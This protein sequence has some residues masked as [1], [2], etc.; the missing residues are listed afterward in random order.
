MY[1]TTPLVAVAGAATKVGVEFDRTMSKVSAITGATGEDFDSLRAKAM[2]L[3]NT[4]KYSSTEI[5][6]AMTF[7]GMAGYDTKQILDSLNGVVSLSIAGGVSL[8]KASD[9]VTDSLTGMQ[10]SAKDCGDFVDIMASTIT[11]SNTSVEL[12][13]ET[14]KYVAPV[15]GALGITM[16]DLS[17]AIG[18]AGN[19]GVKGSQAGTAL[20]GGLTRLVEPTTKAKAAMDKYGIALQK[21]EDGTV[22]L[23]DTLV[24]LR[25]K[26]GK[27]DATTQASAAATIFGKEAMSSWM[28]IINASDDDFQNLRTNINGSTKVMTFFKEGL[29]Q[30]GKEGKEL[31]KSLNKLNEVYEDNKMLADAMNISSTDLGTA[32]ALLGND[33]KVASKNVEGLLSAVFDMQNPTKETKKAMDDLGIEVARLGD[34]SL[35]LNGTLGN[36]RQAMSN[37]SEEEKKAVIESLNLKGGQEDLLEILSLTDDEFQNTTE[38]M[39]DTKGASEKLAEIMGENLGKEIDEMKSSLQTSLIKVFETL[40]PLLASVIEKITDMAN[41]FNELSDAEREQVVKIAGLVACIGPLLVVLGNI[42]SFGGSVAMIFGGMSLAGVSL[43]GILGALSAV[44]IPALIAILVGLATVI[45]DNENAIY[46][47]QEKFGSLGTIVSGVCEFISGA[48]QLTFG[49]LVN[50]LMLVFDLIAAALDGPGGATMEEAFDT[51]GTRIANTTEEAMQK[52]ALSST[53]AMSQLRNATDEQLNGTVQSMDTILGQLPSIIDGNYSEATNALSNQLQN[54]DASQLTILKGMN[55]ST[56]MIFK[57]I[58]EN[59]TVDQMKERLELNFKQMKNTGQMDAE[60]LEKNV[61][62]AMELMKINMDVKTEEGAKEVT[63]NIAKASQEVKNKTDKIN[64]DTTENLDKASKGAKKGSDK[65]KKETTDNLDKAAKNTDAKSKELAN[66]LEKN[67]KD[68]ANKA[69][70]EVKGFSKATEKNVSDANRNLKQSSTDMYKGVCTSFAMMEKKCKQSATNMYKG[71][72]TSAAMMAKNARQ[73]ASDM[74]NGVTTSTRLMANKAI[75]DWQRVRDEYSKG[76]KGTITKKTIIQKP[77]EEETYSTLQ[78]MADNQE[79]LRLSN[80]EVQGSYYNTNTSNSNSLLPKKDD[81]ASKKLIKELQKAINSISKNDNK[82]QL[83]VPLYLDGR[84]LT[85][86]IKEYSD[87]DNKRDA[88]MRGDW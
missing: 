78:A 60:T 32:I 56:E 4:T 66:N 57:E 81:S 38:A 14:M 48:I 69:D 6:E 51:F 67:M 20:R 49:N 76:I 50:L 34:G 2:E 1:V 75:S 86:V 16:K 55:D 58:N 27:L 77:S 46:K 44:A 31:E 47:L 19:A 39:N 59:M 18:L 24:H 11:N 54:M 52:V 21:N 72:K 28:A 45:G 83:E 42:V 23:K 25:D 87:E 30:S 26:M 73:S 62:D 63:D 64:K 79:T 43:T 13:G 9:I 8:A 84:E 70:K 36:L 71:V 35:D 41:W 65:I 15:A 5:A 7:M 22:N 37:M 88:R 10:L 17:L 40:E 85:R 29:E 3:G 12:M 68:G 82:I 61:S 53:R 74:Y 80:Y 33:G